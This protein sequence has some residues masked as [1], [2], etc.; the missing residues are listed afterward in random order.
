MSPFMARYFLGLFFLANGTLHMPDD[1]D[2]EVLTEL[3][4]VSEALTFSETDD[5]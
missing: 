1:I 4:D 2:L 3:E 5:G